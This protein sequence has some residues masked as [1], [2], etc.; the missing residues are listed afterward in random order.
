M[1]EGAWR[2]HGGGFAGTVQVFVPDKMLDTYLDQM[3]KIFGEYACY[4]IFI[5]SI[6]T[7]QIHF[8]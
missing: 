5:R 6:G 3:W 8:E 4:K 2:V 1:N 7:A